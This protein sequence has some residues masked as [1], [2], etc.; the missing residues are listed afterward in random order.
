MRSSTSIP[1]SYRTA[2]V[3]TQFCPLSKHGFRQRRRQ[4]FSNRIIISFIASLALLSAASASITCA[5]PAGTSYEAGDSIIL[6]WGSDGT[7]PVV[8][9]ITS[10]NGTLYCN[11]N[12]AKIADVSIPNVAGPYN[13]TVP[14]VGNAT[15]AGGTVGTCPQNAFHME[16]SGEANGFLG[17]TKIPWGPARC[18]T[19]TIRPAPNGTVTTTTTTTTSTTT[20][21]TITPTSPANDSGG[22]LST[23]AIAIISAV[24]AIIVTLS[25]VAIVVCMRKQRR[26][27][28]MDEALMPWTSNN[29]NRFTKVSSM[30]EDHGP[31]GA[32]ATVAGS[33]SGVG[34]GRTSYEMKPQPT[35]PQPS[36]GAFFPEDGYGYH[37]Q[38]Q[39]LLQQQ[40]DYRN[41]GY[42]DYNEGENYYN[43]YYASGVPSTS[44][45]DPHN[46]SFYGMN[47]SSAPGSN[48][49]P[50]FGQ[51]SEFTQQ[52]HGSG[53]FPPPPP[54]GPL[55]SSLASFGRAPTGNGDSLISSETVPSA[56][57]TLPINSSTSSSPNRAPQTIMQEMGRKEAEEDSNKEPDQPGSPTTKVEVM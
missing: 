50:G 33:G 25:V 17:I 41:Q 55:N 51:S 57:T 36:R 24:A 15:I 35:L 11:G 40:H 31:G 5:L 39:Q 28:K 13:W 12:N 37:M 1:S 38:Q 18:G 19:I 54:Q 2:K 10:I 9:D 42:E 4:I 56:L 22:G 45:M 20:S 7:A 47:N 23:T 16:Y 14:S 44:G 53:Y 46:P 21:A 29:T 49:G 6:D 30:D 34:A 32:G 48:I 27:R 43:P 3:Y 8:T 52:Q 26:R